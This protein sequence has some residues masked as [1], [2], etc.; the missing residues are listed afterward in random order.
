MLIHFTKGI[1]PL[2][3]IILLCLDV[4]TS[5]TM[6]RSRI[7]S[8]SSLAER[9]VLHRANGRLK[10]L[11]RNKASARCISSSDL[12]VEIKN[13]RSDFEKRP[14]K[15]KLCFGNTF[16]DHMLTIEWDTENGWSAPMIL[17]YQD[18]KISP[19]ATSLHYGE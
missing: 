16:T 10:Q 4:T 15:E 11:D 2:N 17:P 18:L 13:D 12:K 19:A 7:S 1:F 3:I 5:S 14:K 6:V 9:F 8:I